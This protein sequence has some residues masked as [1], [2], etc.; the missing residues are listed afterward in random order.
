MNSP[1]YLDT[2]SLLIVAV[3]MAVL[4][5][6]VSLLF[7]SLKRGTQA[8]RLWGWSLLVFALGMGLVALRGRVPDL[9]GV[10]IA[11]TILFAAA[12]PAR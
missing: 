5:G 9:V 4:M 7:G 10:V 11:D 6:L 8:L 2:R 12:I 3:A 1:A